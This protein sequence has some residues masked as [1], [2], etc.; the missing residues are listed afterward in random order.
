MSKHQ[1]KS[2]KC[3]R[4]R[5]CPLLSLVAHEWTTLDLSL[6]NFVFKLVLFE[7]IC[8]VLPLGCKT[9]VL[10]KKVMLDFNNIDS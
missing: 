10:S 3:T 8:S 5:I 6:G 7:G 9:P 4:D 2:S 1:H